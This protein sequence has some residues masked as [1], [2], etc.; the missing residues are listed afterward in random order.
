LRS[1]WDGEK[2]SCAPEDVEECQN[3][4]LKL[5]VLRLDTGGGNL[6]LK[7]SGGRGFNPRVGFNF[8]SLQNGKK[9]AF[10]RF[11]A[12]FCREL[13]ALKA[14]SKVTPPEFL[15]S[16]AGP[17]I[18]GGEPLAVAEGGAHEAEADERTSARERLKANLDARKKSAAEADGL[19][20]FGRPRGSPGGC[21]GAEARA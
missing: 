10:G 8:C 19:R 20:R 7:E 21:S 4:A 12:L 2:V 1:R 13:F 14:L 6:A 15:L 16:A 5:R 3:C 11:G 9:S 18:R 17:K